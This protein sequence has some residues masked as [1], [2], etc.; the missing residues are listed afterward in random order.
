MT[1]AVI[2][3]VSVLADYASQRLA[4]PRLVVKLLTF[5]NTQGILNKSKIAVRALNCRDL[6][7]IFL[8]W[9]SLL[10]GLCIYAVAITVIPSS[11]TVIPSTFLVG[12]HSN[13]FKHVKN[14]VIIKFLCLLLCTSQ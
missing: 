13:T 6:S 12:H 10:F 1:P 3:K 8:F 4:C 9:T 2:R 14:T 5:S 7:L 11:I